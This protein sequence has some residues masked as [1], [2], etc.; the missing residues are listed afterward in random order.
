VYIRSSTNRHLL[1]RNFYR[2]LLSSKV[3]ESVKYLKADNCEVE[4]LQ[5]ISRRKLRNF[6]LYSQVR[7]I[8]QLCFSRS[9]YRKDLH[10]C[11]NIYIT[12]WQ[13][14]WYQEHPA[15]PKHLHSKHL[16]K[17][18]VWTYRSLLKSHTKITSSLRTTKVGN[19]PP[20]RTSH[21]IQWMS[22]A[23]GYTSV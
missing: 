17:N 5:I 11:R 8:L 13:S 22:H 16:G 3:Q 20:T 23:Q 19:S 9:E 14:M 4:V 2:H 12:Q 10:C 6:R 21:L 7:P 15:F 18:S 1:T